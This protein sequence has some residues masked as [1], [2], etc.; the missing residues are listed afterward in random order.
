MTKFRSSNDLLWFLTEHE[1]DTGEHPDL[2]GREPLRLRGVGVDVVEDV[3]ED[4]EESD[5]E[6]HAARHDVGGDEEA[7]PG[8]DDEHAGGEVACDDVVRHLPPQRQLKP[9]HGVI[10]CKQRLNELFGIEIKQN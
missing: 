7:D 2:Y 3:D 1:E 10:T 4:E 5:E 6:R 8:D 9:R